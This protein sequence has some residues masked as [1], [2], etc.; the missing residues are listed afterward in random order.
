[1]TGISFKGFGITAA[2]DNL[3]KMS[4][5]TMSLLAI[6]MLMVIISGVGYFGVMG[7]ISDRKVAYSMQLMT[8]MVSL[9]PNPESLRREEFS[10]P[11][12]F[13]RSMAKMGAM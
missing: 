9:P 1:M 12:S 10:N 11:N 7:M 6:V 3:D 8:C 13:C 5:N 2:L 4:A